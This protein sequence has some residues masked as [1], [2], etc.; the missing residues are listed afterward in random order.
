MRAGGGG[1]WE[2]YGHC[3]ALHR[4]DRRPRSA[5]GADARV[6]APEAPGTFA[7]GGAARVQGAGVL[8][9]GDV[10]GAAL[11]GAV[12]QGRRGEGI[13]GDVPGWR[14][15]EGALLGKTA[16]CGHHGTGDAPA[17]PKGAGDDPAGDARGDGA[18][19]DGERR[20]VAVGTCGTVGGGGGS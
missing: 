14:E 10:D 12:A 13:P 9:Q 8:L 19:R 1:G 2:R 4:S 17:L 7:D 16:V 6:V 15:D 20:G 18:V 5:V 11:Q 3:F